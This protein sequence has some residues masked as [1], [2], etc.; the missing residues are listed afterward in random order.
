M[1]FSLTQ[2]QQDLAA[3]AQ[4]FLREQCSAEKLRHCVD[5]DS[6][7]TN[8]WSDIAAMGLTSLLIPESNGGLGLN[9]IDFALIA[10]EVG[11]TA[12]PEPLS[13]VAGVSVPALVAIGNAVCDDLLSQIVDGSTRV[14]T[15]HSLN[16]FLNQLQAND[17]I[18]YCC[19]QNNNI[20]LVAA[21]QLDIQP[22]Q[23]IDPL[24]RLSQIMPGSL[25]LRSAT[26]LASG[27]LAQDIA[28][29][30]RLHGALFN[31][32]E[33]LGLAAAM[34]DMATEY[35]QQRQQFGVAIGSF[36][37]VKHLLANAFVGIEFARPCLYRAASSLTANHVAHAKIA[38]IDAA[39]QC[40]E[41]AIQ[42]HG[43][44][45]YT[46]E[47]NL[48]L[49]MKRVWSLTGW[50]GDRSFHMQQLDNTLFVDNL[51]TGPGHTF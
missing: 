20:Y 30:C 15:M 10:H 7:N 5:N 19:P 1:N 35:V 40:A 33:L 44:M 47:V 50:W 25:N 29:Q 28:H 36:Q 11:Y 27:Q 3:G 34:L 43:G 38:A 14:L 18:L 17:H 37:A 12:L 6:A 42:V 31:A 4:Q 45:G 32:A 8:L 13:E 16:P 23:S 49:W 22:K 24:R 41:A 21:Q 26:I 51:N 9:A 48:H 39:T 46:F 2:D